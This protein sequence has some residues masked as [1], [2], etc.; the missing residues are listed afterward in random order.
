LARYRKEGVSGTTRALITAVSEEGVEGMTLLD[1]G[2][3]L[4]GIQHA[5]L[6]K[7]VVETIHVDASSAYMRAAQEEAE[8][9]NQADSINFQKGDF[10]DI[11]EG[12]PQADIVTLDRVVCCY[13]DME[14]LVK[15]SAEKARRRYGLVFPRDL[16]LF[17]MFAPLANLVL[18]LRGS[19][20][21][22]FL[23][24]TEQVEW[25]IQS[26]GLTP[27]IHKKKGFWQILVYDRV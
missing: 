10:V 24:S 19:S 1:I 13:D 26:K 20:F 12:I 14:A 2:G 16:W 27:R 4:G 15:L 3:G 9:R 5:L 17:R 25:I 21:R 18:R 8:I 11:A 7:G 23:H 6:D 22:M